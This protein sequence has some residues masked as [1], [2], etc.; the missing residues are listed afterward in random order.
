MSSAPTEIKMYIG[1]REF[2]NIVADVVKKRFDLT[3]VTG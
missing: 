3:P 1:D 2:G